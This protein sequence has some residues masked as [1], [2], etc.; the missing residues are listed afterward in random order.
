MRHARCPHRASPSAAN[1]GMH[2]GAAV[3]SHRSFHSG[4]EAYPERNEL[5]YYCFEHLTVVELRE[6]A[7]Q[8]LYGRSL[9]LKLA[10]PEVVTDHHPGAA[11]T[12]PD[13]PGRPDGLK[14]FTGRSSFEMS[15]VQHLEQGPVR[16]QLL[17]LFANHELLATELMALVLLKFP[18]APP[19]FRRGILKTL[20]DEQEHTRI[21]V[22]RL[23]QLGVEFGQYPVNGFFWNVISPM[24]T[25]LSYV[26]RLSLTFE[27]ANLDYSGYFARRFQQIG[28]AATE[29]IL[30]RIHR[31]EIGHVGYGLKWFRRWKDPAL[32]DW[33][34][35]QNELEFPLSPSRAKAEPFNP[36]ARRK[37]GLDDE[38]IRELFV[39]SKS[40][41]RTP[42]IY[43]FNPRAEIRLGK[44]KATRGE[45][46]IEAMARDLANVPQFL[47]G[48]DD[49]VLVPRQPRT[50]FLAELKQAGFDLPQF[51][52]L[53]QGHLAADSELRRR[54]IGWL[55]PWAWSP[56]SIDVLQPLL[57]QLATPALP[58]G[59][60]W[61][62]RI[63]PLFSKAW[64]LDV[65]R[66]FLER[67]QDRDWLCPE[68]EVGQ[69][70]TDYDEALGLVAALRRRGHVPIVAKQLF[71]SAGNS[72]LR[73]W[74][75][76]LLDSQKTWLRRTLEAEGALVIEPWLDRQLDFSCQM[77]MG[78][79]GLRQ[80]GLVKMV[81]DV[82]GQYQA[83][84]YTPRFTGGLTREMAVFVHGGVGYRLKELYGAL[85]ECLEPKLAAA[86]FQGPLG[87][88][89]LIYRDKT[90]ALCLKPLVEINARFTMGRLMLELMKHVCPGRS[91]IMEL[92]G[93]ARLRQK[94]W[95]SFPEF[96]QALKSRFP[97]QLA[98]SPRAR[99]DCGVLALNDPETAETCLAVLQVG[100]ELTTII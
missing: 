29:Q 22:E 94:G 13:E 34:A 31:D 65:L 46:I 91:A 21:Y 39:Y 95:A 18:E 80:V 92:V 98:G 43:L 76:E 85:A 72:Q 52:V 86:G 23:K 41:G 27:Q 84:V 50:E 70:V 11:S 17:H 64:A 59:P 26:T 62:Q 12:T 79:H 66:E 60:Q 89:A 49:V 25:P 3:G 2:W 71:G 40:K 7:E 10:C 42:T 14:F 16:G 6:L 83:S 8:I 97:L 54:K 37:A 45:R 74:E 56:D 19:S 78:A 67:R 77:E 1:L 44:G 30:A 15:R 48:P 28:D 5:E 24:D 96:A 90:G 87:V 81:N 69:C 63:Q 33:E 100:K 93:K 75:P 57:P 68:A 36:E 9:A 51:E 32:S 4:H 20:R 47:G 53:E 99:I 73:L 82:R 38:F 35:F 55:R 61:A 58:T 88:D